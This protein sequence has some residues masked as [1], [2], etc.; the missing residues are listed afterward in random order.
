[1]VVIRRLVYFFIFVLI[2]LHGNSRSR[3]LCIFFF[4]SPLQQILRATSCPPHHIVHASSSVVCGCPLVCPDHRRGGAVRR[5][6][7]SRA[8]CSG[9]VWDGV[10]DTVSSPKNLRRKE[11]ECVFPLGRLRGGRQGELTISTPSSE[12]VPRVACRRR[13]RRRRRRSLFETRC[14]PWTAPPRPR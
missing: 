10:W 7:S 5:R 14:R 12:S 11:A 13:R 3:A 1:M 9:S 2:S 8:S 6:V 4:F